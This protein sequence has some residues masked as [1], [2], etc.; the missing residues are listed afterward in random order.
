M[1]PIIVPHIFKHG[2]L[3]TAKCENRLVTTYSFS[4]FHRIGKNYWL[5]RSI[6]F[7]SSWSKLS[8]T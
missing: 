8:Q 3:L 4:R 7:A 6:Y 1:K 2:L 5:D